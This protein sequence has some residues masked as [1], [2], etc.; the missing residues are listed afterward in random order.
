MKLG[1][2][3]NL[4][5]DLPLEEALK[6]FTGL[7]IEMVEIGCGDYPGKD[8]ADPDV[9]LNDEQALADRFIP[10]CVGKAS[11]SRRSAP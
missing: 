3:T 7:G 1:V 6:I 11:S 5:G 10:T 4:L 8:H 2:L 9:L